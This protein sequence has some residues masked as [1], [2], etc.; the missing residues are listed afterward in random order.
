MGLAAVMRRKA[1]QV[2]LSTVMKC[3]DMRASGFLGGGWGVALAVGAYAAG[4]GEGG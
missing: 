4:R 3:R 1:C 2:G